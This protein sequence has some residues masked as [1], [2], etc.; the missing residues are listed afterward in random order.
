LVRHVAQPCFAKL[1]HGYGTGGRYCGATRHGTNTTNAKR[2]EAEKL[3]EGHPKKL[4]QNVLVSKGATKQRLAKESGVS[5]MTI[6]RDAAFARGFASTA[7]ERV[8][9]PST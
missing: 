2:Y 4:Q 7:S 5:H 3:V 8:A 1:A 9:A 6:D